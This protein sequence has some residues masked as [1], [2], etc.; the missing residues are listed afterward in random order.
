M[1]SNCTGERSFS[2]LKVVK[3]PQRT[4]IF[5]ARSNYLA[6]TATERDIVKTLPIDEIIQCF[7]KDKSRKVFI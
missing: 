6:I 2:K 5:Q 3:N 1:S 4:S 7:T